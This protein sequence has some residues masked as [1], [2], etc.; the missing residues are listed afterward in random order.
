MMLGRGLERSFKGIWG[1]KIRSKHTDERETWVTHHQ[2]PDYHD[3]HKDNDAQ[4]GA[5]CLLHTFPHILGPF[6]TKGAEH[7]QEGV[8]EITHVPTPG[9]G[10]SLI[11]LVAKEPHANHGKDEDHDGQDHSQVSECTHGV[12]DD[13]NESV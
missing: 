7:H 8:V 3:Q 9:G 5:F 1:E 11:E 2:L 12:A 10:G 6:P 4:R 13:L